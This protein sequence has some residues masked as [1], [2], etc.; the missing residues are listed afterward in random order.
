M[1]HFLKVE[2]LL[3]IYKNKNKK[4]ISQILSKWYQNGMESVKV[5][6]DN[7]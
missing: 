4:S 1:F 6:D 3:P 2:V 5:L 7:F